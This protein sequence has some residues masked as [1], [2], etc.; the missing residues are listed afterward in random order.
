MLVLDH[1][2]I[3]EIDAGERVVALAALFL[4]AGSGDHFSVK[5]DR[6]AVSTVGSGKAQAVEKVGPRVRHVK[7][8]G[9]LGACDDDRLAGV[10]D[11]VG[12]GGG[13]VGHRVR[14][15]ADHKAVVIVVVFFQNLSKFQPVFRMHVCAVDV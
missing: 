9:L 7:V 11:E 8:D 10:L 2:E 6:N 4:S 3:R 1:G 14:S 12:H 5:Y 13:C 15:M